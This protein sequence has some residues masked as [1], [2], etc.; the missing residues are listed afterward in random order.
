MGQEVCLMN[1]KSTKQKVA[2]R[3]ISGIGGKDKFHFTVIPESWFKIDVQQ[4]FVPEVALMW[5]NES[6]EQTKVGDIRGG[7]ALW[8]QKYLKLATP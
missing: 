1:P 6:E 4:V 3:V 5:E 2:S 8:D 7:N